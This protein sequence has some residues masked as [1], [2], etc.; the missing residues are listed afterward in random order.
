MKLYWALITA[1]LSGCGAAYISPSVQEVAQATAESAQVEIVPLTAQSAAEANRTVYT[2][3]SL[4]AVF[5]YVTPTPTPRSVGVLPDPVTEPEGAPGRLETWLPEDLDNSPYLIGV[6][7]VILLATPSS[8]TVEELTGLLAAQNKR[9]GYTVQD[10]GAIAIPDVGRVSLAGLTIEEA[11]NEVFKA[12][13]AAG[14]NPTF[15]VE[16]SEFNSQRVSVGGAVGQPTLVAITLKHLYLEEALQV[17]GGIT[18]PDLDYAS[19]RLYRDGRLYQIPVTQLYSSTELKRI[20]LKDGDSIF[21]DTAYELDQAKDYFEEQIKLL[22]LRATARTHALN[23]LQTE[24]NIRKAQADEARRNFTEREALDAV[25]RDYVYLAG[26]VKQQ[27]RFPLPFEHKAS[28]ADALYS[29][30]GIA[31]RE[32]NVGEIYLLRGNVAGDKVIAYHLNA[33]NAAN[34]IVATRMELRPNDVIFVAEQ[35]ITRWNRVLA[36][37]IPSLITTGIGAAMN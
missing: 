3:R 16:V 7:D 34:L 20:R 24:F 22:N 31:T 18:A 9:Q 30:H 19:V 21:V 26:E 29:S 4:P 15:S 37:F 10:D 36:Q 13:V 25:E 6:S 33:E 32:G 23:E 17:A 12:L 5:G 35:P 14:L 8:N 27:S 1:T 28:L 2:P 11:E